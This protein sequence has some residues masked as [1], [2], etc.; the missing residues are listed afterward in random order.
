MRDALSVLPLVLL[1][2]L[3]LVM[4]MRDFSVLL[5]HVPRLPVN[6]IKPEH[7]PLVVLTTLMMVLAATTPPNQD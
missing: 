3:V 2:V 4:M 5:E 7:L 6:Q 1:L